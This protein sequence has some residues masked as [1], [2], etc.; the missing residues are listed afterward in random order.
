RE[1]EKWIVADFNDNQTE[2]I[3]CS[4]YWPNFCE[5]H[6][7]QFLGRPEFIISPTDTTVPVN[8]SVE[9]TCMASGDP[10]P[11]IRWMVNGKDPSTYLDG[12]RK[13]LRGNH[14]YRDPAQSVN[15][16]FVR[17]FV[18]M[19]SGLFDGN[20]LNKLWPMGVS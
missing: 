10:N 5:E 20:S 1:V 18:T 12:V 4:E 19:A 16:L 13:V 11:Q 6:H 15:S 3:D 2:H 7:E 14:K 9:F 8:G 17:D